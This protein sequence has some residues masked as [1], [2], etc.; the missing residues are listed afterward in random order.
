MTDSMGSA[1]GAGYDAQAHASDGTVSDAEQQRR[2]DVEGFETQLR[3]EEAAIERARA[4]VDK[5]RDRVSAAEDG[6]RG[7]EAARDAIR[8]QLDQARAALGQ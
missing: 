4:G 2:A 7:H 1:G 3:D 5:A 6:V 8:A